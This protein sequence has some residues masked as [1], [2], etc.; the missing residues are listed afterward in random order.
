MRGLS[1]QT[2]EWTCA[3]CIA[4]WIFTHRLPG[5][6]Q[7]EF[8]VFVGY[9]RMPSCSIS[10]LERLEA[11]GVCKELWSLLLSLQ[12]LLPL[13]LRSYHICARTAGWVSHVTQNSSSELLCGWSVLV[14][15]NMAYDSGCPLWGCW[16]WVLHL[17]L[18]HCWMPSQLCS[19][20]LWL[21]NIIILDAPHLLNMSY[22]NHYSLT[23][24]HL[25]I[26]KPL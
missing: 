15:M 12:C 3:P 22:I 11:V 10:H 24:P 16:H 5:K 4:R 21:L 9:T 25:H 2:K 14:E 17:C 13:I 18:T 20:P 6:P 23:I 19:P 7:R 8:M 1:S 26:S